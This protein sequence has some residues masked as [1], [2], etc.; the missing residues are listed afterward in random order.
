MLEERKEQ[1]K[2]QMRKAV[3][4]CEEHKELVICFGPVIASG[5]IELLK[6]GTKRKIVKEEKF[7]KER[8]FYDSKHRH[9]CETK[10]KL[11][12]KEL[13]KLDELL[14]QGEALSR[15]LKDMGLLK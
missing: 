1:A 15:I 2:E 4:W 7:L 12:S 3:S 14:D 9:Y 13:L 8:T 10:R 11:S 6:I 5:L